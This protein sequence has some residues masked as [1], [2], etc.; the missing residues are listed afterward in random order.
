MSQVE[1]RRDDDDES[2]QDDIR[3]KLNSGFYGTAASAP[4]NRD[5]ERRRLG[6]I[7]RTLPGNQQRTK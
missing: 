3:W 7:P 6:F 1:D 4:V 2:W 5:A